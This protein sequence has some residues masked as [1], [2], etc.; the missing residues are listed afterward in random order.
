MKDNKFLTG[1]L[2][3][4]LLGAGAFG[5]LLFQAKGKYNDATN[6]YNDK[7]NELQTLQGGKPYPNDSNFKKEQELQKQHQQAIVALQT[8]L[9]KA[10]LPVEPLT[11][12]K[13]QDN[14]REAI[15]NVT[16]LAAKQGTEIENGKMTLGFEIYTTQP[17]RPEATPQLGRMLKGIEM[18]VTDL[19]SQSPT[20]LADVKRVPMPEEGS[21][22]PGAPKPAATPTPKPG[23]PAAKKTVEEQPLVKRY[24]F[25]LSFVA[26]E[27]KFQKFVNN[28]V[29]NKKQFFVPVAVSVANEMQNGSSKSA[30]ADV[31]PPPAPDPSNP[32]APTPPPAETTKFVVGEE[33]LNVTMR[34][35]LVDFAEPAAEKPAK[36]TKPAPAK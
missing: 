6:A 36:S 7:I 4:T 25:D 1:F 31:A 28:L 22:V 26:Q 33:K 14:L 19:L 30:G 27:P 21:V 9:S 29:S 2:I 3:V 17:P 5:F 10:E 15:K 11:P 18:V 24:P 8:Q 32:N 16:A 23:A 35:E 34:I 20:K 13:F 12:E